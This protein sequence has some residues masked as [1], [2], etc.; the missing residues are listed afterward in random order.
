MDE[1]PSFGPL[2]DGGPPLPPGSPELYLPRRPPPMGEFTRG[3]CLLR[4]EDGQ[5]LAVSPGQGL[6]EDPD[7]HIT[8]LIEVESLARFAEI[9]RI[10]LIADLM[11]AAPTVEDEHMVPGGAA[12]T[13]RIPEFIHLEVG[14]ALQLA[15]ERARTLIG[16][17]LNLKWRHPRL[18]NRM[19]A[20]EMPVWR[21]LEVSR[22]CMMLD[23]AQAL[24][25]DDRIG[26]T[27]PAV[28]WARA[29]RMVEGEIA[30]ADPA[31]AA[32]R[33]RR[34]HRR[35]VGVARRPGSGTAMDLFGVLDA[36]DALQLD[37]TLGRMAAGLADAGDPDDLDARRARALG[38]LARGATPEQVPQVRLYVHVAEGGEIARAEGLGPVPLAELDR[39]TAGATIRVTQ[40]I[41]HA[42]SVP[43]DAY[44]VPDRMREQLVLAHPV[45]VAPYGS[46]T[47]RHCDMDHTVPYVPGNPGQTRPDNLGPLGRTAHR[48][49][50]LGGY[51]LRQD[52]PGVWL[53]S[54]PRGQTYQVSNQG[55]IRLDPD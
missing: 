42:A 2:P 8:E 3:G 53:W 44:E 43:V 52:T 35:R 16:D 27:L 4:G 29:Q 47:A 20:G 15:P 10:A 54:T 17:A 23:H 34:Q 28:S 5:V 50:T 32:E 6:P 39:L 36:A 13:P 33:E 26:D 48:A 41:D 38:L 14:A 24:W 37:A 25:L 40:V 18:W 21:C 9:R 46:V 49:R 51:R 55:T 1:M 22:R 7:E 30:A 19:V 31:A 12:G 11:E 45:E